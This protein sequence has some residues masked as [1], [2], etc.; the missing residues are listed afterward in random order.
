MTAWQEPS[1]QL[2]TKSLKSNPPPCDD[3]VCTYARHQRPLRRQLENQ[4]KKKCSH[5]MSLP[6][7]SAWKV[8]S[9]LRLWQNWENVTKEECKICPPHTYGHIW[10]WSDCCC[11]WTSSPWLLRISS[12]RIAILRAYYP[13]LVNYN[14][15]TIGLLK[16]KARG[17]KKQ[18]VLGAATLKK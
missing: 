4:L 18:D 2:I 17:P 12:F 14:T 9:A 8:F 1:L 5:K 6:R 16:R 15:D 7:I 3:H 11:I 10:N 13:C